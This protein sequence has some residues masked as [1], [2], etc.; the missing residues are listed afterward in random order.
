MGKVCHLV[1]ESPT[2]LCGVNTQEKKGARYSDNP[3]IVTC[4]N[5]LKLLHGGQ[6][7]APPPT[8]H[9]DEDY[10]YEP[11]AK[12]ER[13]PVDLGRMALST[14]M[15]T[16]DNMKSRLYS[17]TMDVKMVM[18]CVHPEQNM[19]YLCELDD[20]LDAAKERLNWATADL[21]ALLNKGDVSNGEEIEHDTY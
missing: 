1:L 15:N 13:V 5:C 11:P 19:S 21:R 20:Y 10:D 6:M 17:F 3:D 2:T 8:Y 16:L 12:I 18:S 9:D 7:G 14:N 4:Q